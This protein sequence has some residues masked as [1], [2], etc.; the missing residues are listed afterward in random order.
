MCAH[1]LDP[2]CL[3]GY[4]AICY[5]KKPTNV[6]HLHICLHGYGTLHV[7]GVPTFSYSLWFFL[8]FLELSEICIRYLAW[9][10]HV[11]YNS[12][13]PYFHTQHTF[14][15]GGK[16]NKMLTRGGCKSQVQSVSPYCVHTLLCRVRSS[17]CLWRMPTPCCFGLVL[18]IYIYKRCYLEPKRVLRLSP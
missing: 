12:V 5:L 17:V 6:E 4:T 7:H 1:F 8:W 16:K 2:L 9:G 14:T 13:I 3:S 15:H 18:P 11:I 10:L